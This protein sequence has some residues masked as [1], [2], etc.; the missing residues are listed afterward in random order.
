LALQWVRDNVAKFGGDPNNVTIYGQSGGAGKVSTLMAMPAAKGLFHKAIIQSG[1]A[2]R[3]QTIEAATAG[4][5]SFMAPVEAK[6]VD[7][8]AAMP[9]QRLIDAAT[10]AGARGAAGGVTFGPVLDGKTLIDGPFDP[11]APALSADIP[12]LIGSTEYEITFFPNTRFYPLDDA[13][14]RNSVKQALPKPADGHI[15]RAVPTD[16]KARARLANLHY[17]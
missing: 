13:A 17:T 15:D 12:L 6:T 10:N 9:M 14:L 4:A 5:R 1:G 3:G 16:P 7:E 2:L 8:L 11:N